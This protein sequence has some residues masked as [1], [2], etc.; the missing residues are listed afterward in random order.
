MATNLKILISKLNHTA[1]KALEKSAELCLAQTN[2]NVELEHLLSALNGTEGTDFKTILK[3]YDINDAR[4]DQHLKEAIEKL[5]RGNYSTPALSPHILTLLEEAWAA[6]SL[7]LNEPEIR[8]GC[9]LYALLNSESLRG[10]LVERCPLLLKIPRSSLGEDIRALMDN[11]QEKSTSAPLQSTASTGSK[12]RREALDLYT[13]DLTAQARAGRIDPVEG[14]DGEVRQIIDILS[15]RRQNNPILTGDAGVGKT[16]VVEGLALRIAKGD[17]S[18]ALKPIE[19]RT[20]DLGLLEAG[21][22]IKGEFENRL[23][24]VIKEVS[25]SP[26]PVILFIDEAHTLIGSGN[27][28]GQ[29]DAANLLK[30]ALARGE[31]RA[32]AATTWSEYKKYF[33]KDA[34]LARRF[35]VVKIAEPDE[36]TAR[37]MLRSLVEKLENHHNV[38]IL[39]EAISAAVG[40]SSRYITGRKLPDKAVSVLDTAC[41]RVSVAHTAVPEAIEMV[42]RNLEA[43]AEERA[44]LERESRESGKD[45][46]DVATLIKRQEELT[47]QRQVLEDQWQGEKALVESIQSLQRDLEKTEEAAV[48][49]KLR[50][51]LS[52]L[53]DKL[54]AIQ[55]RDEFPMVPLNVDRHTVAAVVS[56]WTGIPLGKMMRDEIDTV[57]G[58]KDRLHQRLIGQ[59]YAIDAVAKRIFT[60]RARLDDPTQPNGVFMLIGPSGV[61]KTE[62]A[63]ALADALYGGEQNLITINMSEYQEAYTVSGLKGSPPGYVGYGTGGVLTEAV[64]RRPY[65]VIL[66]DE[67][68]KAHP[69]V[70]ELFY[71]VFDKG[72]L[73]DAEGIEVDFKNTLLFLTTNVGS[74]YLMDPAL[75]PDL[76]L[77][78][79]RPELN[80]LF[81]PA[82][83][84]R[85]TLVPYHPLTTD[86]IEKIVGLKLEKIKGRLRDSHRAKLTWDKKVVA[87]IAAQCIHADTGARN[88]DHILSQHI[89]P[90]LSTQILVALSEEKQFSGAHIDFDNSHFTVMLQ[91]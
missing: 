24:S 33:E 64:R 79:L 86:Q 72:T 10:L 71:Q 60:Y 44:I 9:L 42:D 82:F 1:K 56:S 68:E 7:T 41:A 14:R 18:P 26:H 84:G 17:V 29:S 85:L 76:A 8:T 89:L 67:I 12:T 77:A 37:R 2:F 35:Q 11:S 90:E 63:L 70:L 22:G 32:I 3:Y 15:R 30:P 16:A 83:L 55:M 52:A 49:T 61:G 91:D 6:T 75:T 40:F 45:S 27:K 87:A 58:L 69:D 36:P 80:R 34:A 59:D 62:T 43:I 38:R 53:K 73:E 57:L 78:R 39:D 74:E 23:K 20:L 31:L 4:M 88:I 48:Q 65:S 46:A 81:K 50:E 54:A 47:K 21:A 66:L 5:K 51:Q 28:P 19:L 13:I 25:A